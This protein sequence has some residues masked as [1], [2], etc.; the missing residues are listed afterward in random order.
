MIRIF[1]VIVINE[2]KIEVFNIDLICSNIEDAR[3]EIHSFIKCNRI[4]MSYEQRE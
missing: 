3:R 4:L 2:S 1:K